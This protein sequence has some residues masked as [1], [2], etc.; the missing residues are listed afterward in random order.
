MKNIDPLMILTVLVGL[1][2]LLVLGRFA[3]T[4]DLPTEL[5]TVMG[6]MI[7]GLVTALSTRKKDRDGD[8]NGD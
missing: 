2:L 1:G 3:V 7:G 4:G 8:G 5:L 6:T